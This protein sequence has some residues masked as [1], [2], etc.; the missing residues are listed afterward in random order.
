[1]KYVIVEIEWLRGYG[2]ATPAHARKS[3]D[4]TKVLLHQEYILPVVQEPDRLVGYSYDSPELRNLLEGPE[5][6]SPE[7]ESLPG[8]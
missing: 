5:W 3:I 6:T 1:M 2:I 7:K 8:M 4:G